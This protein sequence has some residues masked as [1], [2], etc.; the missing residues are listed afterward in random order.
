[1]R[2]TTKER[3]LIRSAFLYCAEVPSEE[4]LDTMTPEELR[5]I[6]RLIAKIKRW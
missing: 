4:W 5:L 1:M 3:E 6:D 2:F